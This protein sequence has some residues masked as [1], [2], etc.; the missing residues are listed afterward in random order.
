M[1]TLFISDLHLS[2]ERPQATRRFLDF[3]ARRAHRAR[4][5]YILGDLFE[6]WIGDDAPDAG[7]RE[8]MAALALLTGH[9]VACCFMH[10]NRDFLVG[11]GF[12]A[13]TGCRLLQDPTVIAL[14]GQPTL[15]MHGDTLCTDDVAYQE[16]RAQVRTPQ[17]RDWILAQS[18]QRRRALAAGY[19]QE[20]RA[21][22]REKANA[23]MDVNAGE[24]ERVM[25]AHGVRRLIHGHT[26]RPAEHR[27]DLDGRQAVRWV[28][29]DWYAEGGVLVCDAAGCR[30]QDL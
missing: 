27:F 6:V 14:D 20:S 10:G 16:F 24:V 3:L 13:A 28:L 21:A 22:G 5:L 1:T 18:P 17:W 29:P 7:E 2:A 4:A 8:V 15:L 19:R 25:R 12:A 30:L 26:H 9:G 23:I 11:D